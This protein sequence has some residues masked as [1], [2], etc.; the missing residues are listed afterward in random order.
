M[1]GFT[2]P[3]DQ[4]AVLKLVASRLDTARI[5]YM[6]TGSIA[7]GHYAQPRMTRA[8]D[9]V[10]DLRAG[11]AE[12]VVTL[13]ND[14]FE[15]DLD[16]VRSAIER[17]SLVNLIHTEAI[18]KVD[19]VVRKDSP[20]RLEEFRRRRAVDIDGQSMWMVSPE[21]LVLSKLAWAHDSRSELQLRDVRQV[22][23]A[24]PDLDWAYLDQW[25]G[26]LGVEGLLQEVRG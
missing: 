8:L 9:F 14:Q 22:L 17:R 23:T 12:R 25:A 10:V 26:V 19:F 1:T 18:V 3:H 16:L 6:F 7:A 21:D 20:Y 4:L 13:F 5:P 11:D 24:Q 2:P 15:C